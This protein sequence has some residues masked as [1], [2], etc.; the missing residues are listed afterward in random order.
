[1][2]LNRRF[3]K[4]NGWLSASE[5]LALCV[6]FGGS[7]SSQYSSSADAAM[8]VREYR[9][10]V[11]YGVV[12]LE[13]ETDWKIKGVIEKGSYSSFVNAGIYML[14]SEIIK[15]IPKDTYSNMTDVFADNLKKKQRNIAFPIREYWM[16]VGRLEDFE[17][18]REEFV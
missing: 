16:D 15:D 17:R 18:A 1:M 14:N 9:Y 10:Q 12:D 7:I 6:G 3:S 11:P 5:R 8:C 4:E 13:D 2:A